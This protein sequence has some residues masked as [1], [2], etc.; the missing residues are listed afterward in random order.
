METQT[1]ETPAVGVAIFLAAVFGYLVL[2]WEDGVYVVASA[3]SALDCLWWVVLCFVVQREKLPAVTAFLLWGCA[4]WALQWLVCY[5]V[6][7]RLLFDGAWGVSSWGVVVG[8]LLL[9]VCALLALCAV[10]LA[11]R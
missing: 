4:T 8:V 9:L 11:V 5:W 3:R 6:L 2:G 10:L 1:L 7:P